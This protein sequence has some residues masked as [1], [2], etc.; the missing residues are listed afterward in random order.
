MVT[1]GHIFG[2]S[3]S[4][5]TDCVRSIS[6]EWGRKRFKF[7]L[8]KY[9][10]CVW[11]NTI[12]PTYFSVRTVCLKYSTN[13]FLQKVHQLQAI[14]YTFNI[15]NCSLFLEFREIVR[16]WYWEW[17]CSSNQK[18]VWASAVHNR[19]LFPSRRVSSSKS[20]KLRFMRS[21]STSNKNQK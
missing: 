1:Y 11:Q 16:V 18:E 9:Y 21:P 6:N 2:A 5:S 12:I 13:P 3:G 7:C 19:L 17:L 14:R 15:L 10:M 8:L 20:L 4:A